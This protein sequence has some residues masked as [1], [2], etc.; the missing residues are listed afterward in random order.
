MDAVGASGYPSA[1]LALRMVAAAVLGAVPGYERERSGKVAGL[2]THVLVSLG[3]STLVVATVA[4]GGGPSEV[5]HVVQGAAAGIGFIGA[6][7]ILK[8]DDAQRVHGITTAASIWMTAAIGV[9]A[10]IGSFWIAIAAAVLSF[11]TLR[12]LAHLDRA[13]Q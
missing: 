1:I 5:A 9:S 3:S 13:P 8:A 11:V 2:R 12:L 10:G 4:A 7:A 6:G